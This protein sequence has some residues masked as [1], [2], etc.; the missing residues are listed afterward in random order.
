MVYTISKLAYYGLFRYC[1]KITSRVYWDN[2]KQKLNTAYDS[3]M[4]CKKSQDKDLGQ[5]F[6]KLE[7][8]NTTKFE[9]VENQ[10]IL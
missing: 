9:S 5:P 7:R 10:E 1:V 2:Q 8:Y 3:I 6:Q 4:W